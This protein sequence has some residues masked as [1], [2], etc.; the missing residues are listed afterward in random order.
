MRLGSHWSERE[1]TYYVYVCGNRFP[2]L[3]YYITASIKLAPILIICLPSLGRGILNHAPNHWDY[4][5]WDLSI[6]LLD[7]VGHWVSRVRPIH[8]TGRAAPSH[9]TA[10]QFERRQQFWPKMCIFTNRPPPNTS[11]HIAIRDIRNYNTRL[12]YNGLYKVSFLH[13]FSL[14]LWLRGVGLLTGPQSH[15]LLTPLTV[16]VVAAA[17]I[18]QGL[19]RRH[20]HAKR[21]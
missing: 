9:Y 16:V 8:V 7:L 14:R 12:R 15:C 5:P 20:L 4:L 21:A 11:A 18:W 10:C 17:W 2:I 13:S 1:I 3:V 19:F 6:R